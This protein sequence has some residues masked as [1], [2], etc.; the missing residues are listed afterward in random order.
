M[1]GLVLGINVLPSRAAPA[2][3]QSDLPLRRLRLVAK[4]QPGRYGKIPVLH[5][6]FRKG[7]VS[8]LIL[9]V[10]FPDH[11]LCSL[12]ANPRRSQC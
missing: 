8:S 5:S 4:L 11:Q 7:R 3:K 2:A 12:E 1:A 9:Q 10:V 6:L